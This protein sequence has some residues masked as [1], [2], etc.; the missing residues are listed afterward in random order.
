MKI[1]IIGSGW[2]GC[3]I[4]LVLA[5]LGYE[6]TILEKNKDIFQGT[7]G[8]FGIRLHEGPHYPRSKLTRESCRRNGEEFKQCYPELVIPHCYSLDPQVFCDAYG[9][10]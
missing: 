6:V 5:K 1:Y 4:A 7:S 10:P 3:H 9:L 8:Q 2:Y